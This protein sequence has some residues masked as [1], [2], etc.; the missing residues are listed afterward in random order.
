MAMQILVARKSA[1]LTQRELARAA[2]V[3]QATV[4]LIEAGKAN[5]TWQTLARICDALDIE[6][7]DFH[8]P[9]RKGA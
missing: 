9:W 5:P 6:Q 1:E 3:R 8:G 4:A 7:L 2:G